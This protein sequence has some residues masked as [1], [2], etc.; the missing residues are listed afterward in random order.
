MPTPLHATDP[1][2]NSASAISTR[3]DWQAHLQLGFV[4]Q[5]GVTRLTERTHSGPLRVQKALYPELPSVCHTIIVHPPGGVVGGDQLSISVRLGN[6]AAALLAT[7]GAA[8]W[9]RANGRV[10]R[11]SVDLKVAAG[12]AL[13]WLPQETILYNG[14]QV[15]FDSKIELAADA[16]Y[17]GCEILCFGRAASGEKFDHGSVR[18]HNQIRRNGTLIWHEQGQL[19]GSSPLM[20][21]P[22][23]LAGKTVCATLLAAAP[24]LAP[25]TISALR[26][27]AG[28]ELGVTYM[29][30]I[31]AVRYLGDSSEAARH[32]MLH[33]WKILRPALLGR[34][35]VVP[36]IWN[37]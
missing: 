29:K 33:A 7:P 32:S 20:Q 4:K 8:K 6:G 2:I 26:N 13:E 18:Q 21:S 1:R 36:R 22:F 5:D 34:L 23:G 30:S 10:S 9:Y 12:A 3:T 16:T 11:Q 25:T 35:A 17:I 24:A 31:L 15:E 28:I 37:T 14:A 19:D 27:S